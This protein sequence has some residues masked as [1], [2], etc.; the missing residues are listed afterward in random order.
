MAKCHSLQE[1]EAGLKE[2]FLNHK[3]KHLCEISKH[4]RVKPVICRK[5]FICAER[6]DIHL[7]DHHQMHRR[8]DEPYKEIG[9]FKKFT[10][11][12]EKKLSSSQSNI[13]GN[14]NEETENQTPTNSEEV[15]QSQKVSKDGARST[16]RE[17]EQ[18][19]RKGT[20]EKSSKVNGRKEK[21]AQMLLH[22][23]TLKRG[24]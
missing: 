20:G 19:N 12:Y 14:D 11:E 21:N 15:K 18:V 10:T 9:K 23:Y 16:E 13:S 24:L 3:F 7:N 22:Y 5:C 4:A 8:S 1:K 2:S 6:I 17:K